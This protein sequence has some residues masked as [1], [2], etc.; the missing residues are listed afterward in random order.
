ME[1]RIG[2][3]NEDWIGFNS[4]IPPDLFQRLTEEAEV[5]EVSRNFLVRKALERYLDERSIVKEESVA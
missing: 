3:N 1:A 5:R 2:A 4:R